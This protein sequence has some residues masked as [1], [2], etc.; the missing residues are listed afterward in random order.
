MDDLRTMLE[1]ASDRMVRVAEQRLALADIF[2]AVPGI[3]TVFAYQPPALQPAHLAAAMLLPGESRNQE[4]SP[5]EILL[6]RTWTA[7]VYVA[8]FLASSNETLQE[9]TEAWLDTLPLVLAA[10]PRIHLEDGRAFDT[11]VARTSAPVVLT[12]NSQTYAGVVQTFTTATRL[13]VPRLAR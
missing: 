9:M 12:Y 7:R 1:T 4:L 10:Y 11:S 5:Q 2:S 13:F 3:R 6:E 8:P